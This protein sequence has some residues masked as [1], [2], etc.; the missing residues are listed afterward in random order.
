[1]AIASEVG[2]GVGLGVGVGVGVGGEP[3]AIAASQKTAAMARTARLLRL[4]RSLINGSTGPD[5]G[6]GARVGVEVGGTRHRTNLTAAEEA[7]HG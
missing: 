5:Y 3:H 4:I 7:S 2:V 6:K 1:M